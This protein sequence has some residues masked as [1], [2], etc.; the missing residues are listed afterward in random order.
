EL[1]PQ[2]SN[3]DLEA[4]KACVLP[5]HQ[6]GPRCRGNAAS[7]LPGPRG[8]TC[9]RPRHDGWVTSDRNRPSRARMTAGQRREQ[10]LDVSRALF[11]EKGFEGTSVEEVR[12]EEHTSELQS[13]ENLVC[14]LLLDK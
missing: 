14:R 11:A 13:R 6:G 4:P 12:S 1:R 3:P 10:L 2:D 7:S 8:G 9:R 5:L